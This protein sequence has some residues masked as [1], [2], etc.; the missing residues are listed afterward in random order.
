MAS[1]DP[2]GDG[3]APVPVASGQATDLG[4]WPA[5][6][7]A[8]TQAAP[9]GGGARRGAA[10]KRDGGVEAAPHRQGIV[11]AGLRPHIPAP[12]RSRVRSQRG[13]TQEGN[14]ARQR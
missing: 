12:S 14:A 9:A 5:G 10:R 4:R 3:C 7:P 6:L 2:P 8:L 11:N 13:R 1:L